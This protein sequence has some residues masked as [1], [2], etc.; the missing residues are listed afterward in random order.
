M[1]HA[2]VRMV[3]AGTM[4]LMPSPMP[5]I[6]ALKPTTFRG[7][8]SRNATS[9]P[10]K[11]PKTSDMDESQSPKASARVSPSPLKNLPV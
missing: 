8:K 1:V 7:I 11:P 6:K 4:D 5:S 2:R 3:Q 9:S 10:P